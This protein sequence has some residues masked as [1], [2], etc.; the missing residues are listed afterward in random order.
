MSG[1]QD[2]SPQQHYTVRTNEI[3]VKFYSESITKKIKNLFVKTHREGTSTR[4][5][6]PRCVLTALLGRRERCR[7]AGGGP[8]PAAPAGCR[9]GTA[10]SARDAERSSPRR[11]RQLVARGARPG[12]I[13]KPVLRIQIHKSEVWI[14]LSIRLRILPFPNKCVE[15]TE[16]KL[17]K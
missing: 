16:V 1:T 4:Q 15:R 3:T 17:A 6:C 7:R 5:T 13:G 9:T 12:I 11:R 8:P 14:R 10:G 2:A